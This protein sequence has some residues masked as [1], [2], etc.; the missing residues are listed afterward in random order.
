LQL[1]Q[2]RI[3]F[4]WRFSILETGSKGVAETPTTSSVRN[5]S[6][7]SRAT[8]IYN[9]TGLFEAMRISD[10]DGRLLDAISERGEPLTV[11][12]AEEQAALDHFSTEHEQTLR[13]VS[14]G[15]ATPEPSR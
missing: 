8:I 3:A 6:E 10:E 11:C 12:T 15:P 7:I 1:A 9:L 2:G 5:N 4:S 13:L 14:R